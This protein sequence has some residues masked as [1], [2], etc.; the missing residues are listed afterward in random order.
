MSFLSSIISITN[1][2]PPARKL[3]NRIASNKICTAIE[4]RP[5]A[6]ST[7]SPVPQPPA[8][9]PLEY[10]PQGPV[11][12]YTSWP[13]LTDME[14]SAR[15]LPPAPD[16]FINTL[17]ADAQFNYSSGDMGEI[18]QLFLRQTPQ[19]ITGRSSTLFMFFAQWFTDSVLRINPIDRRKNTS[20]HNIDLCQ[21]YGLTEE[22]ASILRNKAGGLGKLKSQINEQGEEF[23]A[24]LGSENAEGKWQVKDEFSALPYAQEPRLSAVFGKVPEDRKSNLYATGLERGNSSVGYVAINTL[25]MRE[26]N[27][28]CDELHIAH[29]NWDDERLFQTARMINNILLMKF[30]VQDY[31]G[32]IADSKVFHLDHTFAEK[33]NWYRK[34]WIALE[35]DLLYRWHS[36]IP[37]R[38]T[39]GG[40]TYEQDEYRFNNLILE[41]NGLSKVLSDS[42]SQAAGKIGL[43]NVPKFMMGAEY[44][45]IRM[46][47][48]FKL[49]SF[50]AY[51]E[52]FG[53]TPL[54]SFKQLSSD[55]ALVAELERLYGDI[56]HLEL[57]VGLFAEEAK[58]DALF[59]KLM[60]TMV[61]YDAFTQIYTN[62][63][64]S[65]NVYHANTLSQYGIDLI[66]KTESIVD[67]AARNT[68][69]NTKIS[70][71]I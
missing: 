52:K 39:F 29:P 3:I 26:H 60:N 54:S 58:G 69:G 35:F 10:L 41:K 24:Y 17:P 47:R 16:K 8:S 42:S 34:P 44:A 57:T 50:N 23:L 43:K 70:F 25:F 30:V 55:K 48:D 45:M 71:G 18:T 62:P 2:I 67:F 46:G 37:D 65:K 53:L 7:W 49:Q 22:T 11:S 13:M 14:Y 33:Q 36:M 64:L 21:I 28:I 68:K 6:F 19:M 38:I 61:A 27:R 40:K 63:L 12:E 4:P 51:R 5:R 66:E 56:D 9:K 1:K 59:G 31:I 15:H 20:N 32:H